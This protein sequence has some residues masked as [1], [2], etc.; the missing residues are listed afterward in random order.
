MVSEFRT[1]PPKMVLKNL[2]FLTLQPASSLD[3]T[4]PPTHPPYKE[5]TVGFEF[6]FYALIGIFKKRLKKY[7][8]LACKN[9]SYFDIFTHIKELLIFVNVVKNYNVFSLL[10]FT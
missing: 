2:M 4:H 3:H 9:V 6:L 10:S 1:P 7:V 5:N 8:Y